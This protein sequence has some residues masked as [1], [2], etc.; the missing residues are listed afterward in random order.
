MICALYN[1][2]LFIYCLHIA[3][4]A[5]HIVPLTL[6]RPNGD[7]LKV[8]LSITDG[9]ILQER[10]ESFCAHHH[11]EVEDCHYLLDYSTESLSKSSE[12]DLE[13]GAVSCVKKLSIFSF[14]AGNKNVGDSSAYDI[15]EYY[16]D[17]AGIRTERVT[18]GVPIP[19]ATLVSIGSGMQWIVHAPGGV[20]ITV[21]GT[22]F[23]W[24]IPVEPDKVSPSLSIVGVRG[25]LSKQL[26]DSAGGDNPTLQN[27]AVSSDPGLLL[28]VVYPRPLVAA[29][30]SELKEVGFIIHRSDRDVFFSAYPEYYHLLIDNHIE[31]VEA[32]LDSLWKYKRV[33]S[34]SL[35]GIIFSHAYG[36]PV[37]GLRVTELTGGEFKFKDYMGSIAYN[38]SMTC[39]YGEDCSEP[40][41]SYPGRTA[42]EDILNFRSI[43]GLLEFVDNCWQ[44]SRSVVEGNM[45]NLEHMISDYFNDIA[46]SGA[47]A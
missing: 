30:P 25:P 16:A 10:L 28:P 6:S 1:R 24:P 18:V 41:F 44:P 38:H 27:V 31:S 33:V 13:K 5:N 42:I 32:F 36:I 11:I 46:S 8:D 17:K 2:F 3:A 43:D 9:E 35:H 7:I 19:H 39:V 4:H 22:G 37:C 23:I 40:S 29:I 20:P 34:S 15:M 12:C 45:G 21:I 47:L 14:V 26:I